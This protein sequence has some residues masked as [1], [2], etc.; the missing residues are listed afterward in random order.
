MRKLRDLGLDYLT[1]L[2]G[3]QSANAMGISDGS[4]QSS[5][6]HLRTG[7][8]SNMITDL[9]LVSLL[10]AKGVFTAEEYSEHIRVAANEEVAMREEEYTK[11][12]GIKVSFR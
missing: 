12:K 10:I 5:P 9:G 3:V 4:I 2:H 1:A 7:I 11:K 6:K 8:D